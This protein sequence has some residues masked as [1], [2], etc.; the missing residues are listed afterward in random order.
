MFQR[1]LHAE[2]SARANARRPPSL[3]FHLAFQVENPLFLFLSLCTSRCRRPR[4]SRRFESGFPRKGPRKFQRRT[5][6]STGT[7]DKFHGLSRPTAKRKAL[8]SRG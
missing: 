1:G 6:V 3:S 7:C 5:E 8:V 4:R 2:V